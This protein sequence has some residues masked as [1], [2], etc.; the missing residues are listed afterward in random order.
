MTKTIHKLNLSFDLS[1]TLS[2]FKSASSKCDNRVPMSRPSAS[3]PWD[4]FKEKF[5]TVVQFVQRQIIFRSHF[6]CGL[7]LKHGICH[8]KGQFY[9]SVKSQFVMEIVKYH[10]VFVKP[11]SE[12]RLLSRTIYVTTANM[13]VNLAVFF[14]PSEPGE[15]Y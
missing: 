14:V 12:L 11:L 15:M 4:L 13:A 7:I 3:G 10:L 9:K 6:K 5:C 2:S 8:F 1:N